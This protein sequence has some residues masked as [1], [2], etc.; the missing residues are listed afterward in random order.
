MNCT[1]TSPL[2]RLLLSSCLLLLSSQV[3]AGACDEQIVR[4]DQLIKSQHVE[5]DWSNFWY[6]T[7][8]LNMELNKDARLTQHQIARL[9][10][11]RRLAIRLKNDHQDRMCVEA[12]DKA[13]RHIAG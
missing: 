4:V 12:I 2:L 1:M 8:L 13:L 5:R 6:C 11:S 9:S 3:Y 10:D 7:I